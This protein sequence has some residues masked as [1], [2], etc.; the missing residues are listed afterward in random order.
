MLFLYYLHNTVYIFQQPY[1]CIPTTLVK[2]GHRHSPINDPESGDSEECLIIFGWGVAERI[3]R[4]HVCKTKH[5][6]L[7]MK[8]CFFAQ[9]VIKSIMYASV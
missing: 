6:I 5:I 1:L 7:N 9:G 8:H 2:N 4:L 3:I